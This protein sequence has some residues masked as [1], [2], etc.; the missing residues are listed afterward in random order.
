MLNP[1]PETRKTQRLQRIKATIT[2]SLKKHAEPPNPILP[3]PKPFFT[4]F[5]KN[6][7]AR[8]NFETSWNPKVAP[9]PASN[10]FTIILSNKTGNGNETLNT[11]PNS[12]KRNNPENTR[13]LQINF[14]ANIHGQSA[15]KRMPFIRHVQVL[16][17]AFVARNLVKTRSQSFKQRFPLGQTPKISKQLINQVPAETAIDIAA[18]GDVNLNEKATA[19][20]SGSLRFDIKQSS[21]GY[22]FKFMEIC[23]ETKRQPSQENLHVDYRGFNFFSIQTITSLEP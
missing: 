17:K 2:E 23:V 8:L 16:M 4:K 3:S 22:F 1:Q 12:N 9:R 10:V 6:C 14:A 7:F 20:H 15:K 18:A 21:L 5:V 11:K 13:R 19:A